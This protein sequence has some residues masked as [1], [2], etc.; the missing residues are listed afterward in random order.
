MDICPYKKVLARGCG[1]IFNFRV[2]GGKLCVACAYYKAC[3]RYCNKGRRRQSCGG[4]NRA[5]CRNCG[6][7]DIKRLSVAFKRICKRKAYAFASQLSFYTDMP[8]KIF[9]DFTLSL[10]RYIKPPYLR[11]RRGCIKLG[12][13]Y[14]E[15]CFN[16]CKN[17][18][19]HRRND[20]Y[21]SDNRG[22]DIG[23]GNYRSRNRQGNKQ[24][25]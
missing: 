25:V 3:A 16:R 5:F 7:G 23:F 8:Q 10:R 9:A 22:G 15:R 6:A 20:F 1:N 4:G 11:C 24:K 2:Y 13:D 19:G 14:T 18:G 21:E 12:L 17:N